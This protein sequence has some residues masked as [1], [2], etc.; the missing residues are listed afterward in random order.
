MIRLQERYE[1]DV[2]IQDS[3][4]AMRNDSGF[5]H[6]SPFPAFRRRSECTSED[7]SRGG[8]DGRSSLIS[9]VLVRIAVPAGQLDQA[10]TDETGSFVIIHDQDRSHALFKKIRQ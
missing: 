6:E 2:K 9:Q 3:T 7:I 4:I 1:L 5:I 10:L 8:T